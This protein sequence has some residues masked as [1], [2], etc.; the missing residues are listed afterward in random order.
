MFGRNLACK[1]VAE[2]R[3][4]QKDVIAQGNG[5]QIEQ[6]SV[7]KG[8]ARKARRQSPARRRL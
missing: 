2:K 4:N 5:K 3:Q 8:G 1:R 7:T 6:Q